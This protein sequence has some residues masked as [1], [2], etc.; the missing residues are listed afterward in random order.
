MKYYLKEDVISYNYS[1]YARK[2]DQ[3]TMVSDRDNV[4]I[5]ED[6]KGYRF[7]VK[8]TN[9]SKEKIEKDDTRG[10]NGVVSGRPVPKSR[11]SR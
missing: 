1:V 3:V 4:I 2:G 7:S 6:E 11:R 5:A 8:K 10:N 9:L